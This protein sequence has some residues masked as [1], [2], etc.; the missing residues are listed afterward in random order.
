M[1]S[2]KPANLS[3]RRQ[4]DMR[5]LP[6][7]GITAT[8]VTL[9][10]LIKSAFGVQ[11]SQIS[12]GPGWI[13]SEKYDILAKPEDGA[14]PEIL[15]MLQ[16]LLEDRFK[17]VIRSATKES[18]VYELKM[19]RADGKYG[20]KLRELAAED[21]PA[22]PPRS[23][24]RGAAPCAGFLSGK[25]HLSGHRVK[26]SQLTSPLSTILERPVLDKTGLTIDFDL[27]LY[28]TPEANPPGRGDAAPV[29]PDVSPSSIFAALKEQLGL[30]LEGARGPVKILVIEH[31][32][33]PSE[34]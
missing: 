34:N 4:I 18:P 9:Q 31:A 3:L 23:V 7:G 12:G 30:K 1:T 13:T 17:L 15:P 33:R 29:P 6:N 8:S 14:K 32:E 27:D 25:N 28:W 24:N 19:A 5:A 22:A 11:D 21:C 16:A 2:V 26:M 10:F 20:P